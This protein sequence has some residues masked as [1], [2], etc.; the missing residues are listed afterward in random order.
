[1]D[2][3]MYL[4]RDLEEITVLEWADLFNDKSYQIV[5]QKIIDENNFI[6]T[7]WLGLNHNFSNNG[8]PL[9]FETAIFKNGE[10]EIFGRCSTEKQAN[11]MHGLA[12]AVNELECY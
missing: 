12:I 1:M 3:P 7:V 6:S 2:M 9:I 10:C 8:D 5:N 11:E 4:N